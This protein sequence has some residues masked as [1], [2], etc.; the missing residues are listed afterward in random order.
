MLWRWVEGLL[1]ARVSDEELE[2]V[3]EFA[4]ELR[5][6]SDAM[7]DDVLDSEPEFRIRLGEGGRKDGG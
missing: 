1:P 5:A 6:E 7:L 3:K 4:R 2:S